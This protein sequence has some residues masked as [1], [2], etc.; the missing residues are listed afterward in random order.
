MLE[1]TTEVKMLFCS[2][3]SGSSGNCQ[4][5]EYKNTQILIDAGHSGKKITELLKSIDKKVEDVD[6]IF[7]THEHIDHAKGVGVLSRKHNIKVF[8]TIET[9]RSM[10]PVTKEIAAENAY[11]F[12]NGQ[13]FQFK[14]L[15][16]QP[17]QSFHDCT[18]GTCF[19]VNGNK[20]ISV[21][22]DT[23][24]VNPELLSSMENS[25]IYYLES[26]HDYDM[27]MN[28]TY[29]W[30]LK[31]R[32]SSTRGH[33]SNDN[34]AE[35]LNR[36][37][38]KKNEIVMLSHLSQDNNTHTIASNTVRDLLSQNSIIDGVDYKLEVSPRDE[39]S[40]HEI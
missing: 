21:V 10:Q 1:L 37:I 40:L 18:N 34:A 6:A 12:V 19:I 2:L 9:M 22:T 38:K 25:D 8:S 30:S 17:M 14:D 20:K 29:P 16:I 15:Y 7:V 13:P 27:L 39:V 33:L 3:S 24:Y 23:G 4:Y 36:L 26:N 35:I 31:S 5:I 32:I 11:T 28:G